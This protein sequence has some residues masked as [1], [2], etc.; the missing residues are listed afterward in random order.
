MDFRNV[1]LIIDAQ[2]DF[3]NPN[4]AL[5]VKGADEDMQRL[6]VFIQRNAAQLNHIC[7]SLDAHR[8][9]DI[10]HPNF[11]E[12]AQGKHPIPFTIITLQD[13]ITKKWMPRFEPE[14][15]KKYLQLLEKEGQFAHFIWPMHCLIG[16]KGAALDD[17]IMTAIS[18]WAQNFAKQYEVVTKRYYPFSEHFGVFKA[19]VSYP[20]IVETQL[21]TGL[22]NTLWQYNRVFVAGEA[23]SHCVATSLQQIIRYAPALVPKITVLTDTM[24][25]VPNLGYLGE[26]TYKQLQKMGAAFANAADLVL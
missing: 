11:W 5:Y 8:V 17:G 24:S 6:T 7:V 16:S 9:N 10:A 18:Q 19:Q 3:C 26:P 1:L 20:T 15:V 13:L 4:G 23:K 14:I 25:D 21:N 2:Y 22:L 12:N